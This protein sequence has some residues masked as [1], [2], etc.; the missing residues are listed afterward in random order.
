MLWTPSHFRA[1]MFCSFAPLVRPLRPNDRRLRWTGQ[2]SDKEKPS[3]PPPANLMKKL[4]TTLTLLLSIVIWGR[5]TAPSRKTLDMQD[6]ERRAGAQNWWEGMGMVENWRIG[7]TMEDV[8]DRQEEHATLNGILS[9][10]KNPES[11]QWQPH[12]LR[13]L[14]VSQHLWRPNLGVPPRPSPRTLP[15]WL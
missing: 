15:H 10:A 12:S 11:A 3:Q 4:M 1:K 7:I 13:S 9:L 5:C 8:L 6:G 2:S 14:D